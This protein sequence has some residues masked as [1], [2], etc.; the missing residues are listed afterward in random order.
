MNVMP[1][2][3]PTARPEWIE[4]CITGATGH[5]LSI[6]ANVLTAMEFDHGLRDAFA[7][8]EM[9]RAPMLMH[10]IGNP[11]CPQFYARPLND[12][13]I[14]DLVEYLQR[15]GLKRIAKEVARDAAIARARDCAFHPVRQYLD[16]LMWD[17]GRRLNTWLAVRLGA[18][19]TPYTQNIGTMFLLAMVA[20][21]YDPGC[22][23]DYMAV[24]EGPQGAM[25]S[26]ACAILGGEW[27]SDNL[28]EVGEGKDVS[29]H[30]AGKWLIEIA[31]MHAMSRVETAQLKA[32]YHAHH[33]TLSTELRPP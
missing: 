5:P 16:N 17:G 12:T 29:Q 32:F 7:L 11:I 18:E 33:R 28:P 8:D 30:I 23:A 31:E 21:I 3:A 4:R 20:R 22:K 15:H 14:T 1:L 10:P 24:L 27:F 2:R 6:L 9:L 26:T 25:K 13:D 19:L